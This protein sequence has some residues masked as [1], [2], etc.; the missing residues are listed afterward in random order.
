MNIYIFS[1][2]INNFKILLKPSHNIESVL[3]S[4]LFL[5]HKS[6]IFNPFDLARF[7]DMFQ[8]AAS[9]QESHVTVPAQL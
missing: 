8:K 1:S 5:S 7:Q 9:K 2:P 3:F 4:S 6:A